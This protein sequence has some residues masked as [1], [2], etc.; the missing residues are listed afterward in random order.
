VISEIGLQPEKDD[1]EKEKSE[2]RLQLFS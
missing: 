1:G 2:S